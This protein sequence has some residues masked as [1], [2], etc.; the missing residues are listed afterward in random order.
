LGFYTSRDDSH[1]GAAL[2]VLSAAHFDTDEKY[3]GWPVRY[4]GNGERGIPATRYPITLNWRYFGPEPELSSARLT[5][6]NGTAIAHE[7]TTQIST[8]HKGIQI[9]PKRAL[10]ANSKI[11]V[12][13]SGHYDDAPFSYSWHFY[14][15]AVQ[16]A[17][18][19]MEAIIGE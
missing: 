13:V 4:P 2:D 5:R 16:Y 7:A 8:G 10:P 17:S 11:R 19:T 1:A 6:A 9:I 3:A 12:S 15:S 18:P 14:T